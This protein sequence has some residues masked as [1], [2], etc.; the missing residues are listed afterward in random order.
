MLGAQAPVVRPAWP[1]Y[2]IALV[3]HLAAVLVGL[4]LLAF[5]VGTV[6]RVISLLL[7]VGG[8]AGAIANGWLHY[9]NDP[10]HLL[11]IPVA[12]DPYPVLSTYLGMFLAGAMFLAL[13]LFVSSMVRD[14]LVAAL[15]SLALGAVFIAAGFWPPEQ[16]GELAY[17]LVYFFSVP[18][19]FDRAFTRGVIDT[20]PLVLYASTT[21]FCLFLTVR[22]LERR[23]WA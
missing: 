23:R 3:A 11:E 8:A 17:Q 15:I 22:S 19:H 16:N 5:R 20:R 12:L 10:Q 18:L 4:L 21:L 6:G 9:H 2:G 7:I 14:Q 13:G 1:W